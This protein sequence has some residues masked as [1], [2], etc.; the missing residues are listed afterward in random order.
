MK[1]K[2]LGKSEIWVSAL[3]LGLMP[4]AGTY[5]ASVEESQG[6]N[7]L[8]E[9]LELGINFWDTADI[10]GVDYSGEKFLAPI[11]KDRREEVILATKFGFCLKPGYHD[12]FLP[13]STYLNTRPEYI[14]Q[15]VD[16]SLLRLGTDYIDLYYQH[17]VD[18]N[19]PIEDVAR[20]VKELIAEGKV[21]HWGL[22]EASAATIRRAHAICPLTAVQ[23]E[24]SMIFREPETNG[25]LDTCRELG[26][27]FV[28]FS[29]LGKGFL[30]NTVRHNAKFL[31]GDVR[32]VIPKF[33]EENMKHNEKLLDIVLKMAEKKKCTPGQIALA[34]VLAQGDFIV[35]IPGTK[36]LSRL[37]ENIGASKVKLTPEELKEIR[38]E[39]DKIDLRGDRYNEVNMK[40]IDHS[41]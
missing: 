12:G 31:D 26:I 23:S 10:Y 17:R 6:Y 22:S 4:L 33:N 36:S 9:A 39:L 11:L 20:C 30:T 5:G 28:P 38:T 3:G 2:E 13:N 19:V 27:G 18:P 37:E 24:Y 1:Y 29:P 7:L 34:W 40:L 35:P 41:K 14:H 21:R 16:A 32:K 25:V 8:E 15:A